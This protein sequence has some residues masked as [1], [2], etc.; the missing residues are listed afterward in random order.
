MYTTLQKKSD[1]M[2]NLKHNKND[3][4]SV[5]S[6]L[7]AWCAEP[8]QPTPSPSVS[9]GT[10]NN[11]LVP[12]TSH[13]ARRLQHVSCKDGIKSVSLS[14]HANISAPKQSNS[15]TKLI[16]INS[17]RSTSLQLLMQKAVLVIWMCVY[18]PTYI[19]IC[20]SMI[21]TLQFTAENT[22]YNR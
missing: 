1:G 18:I 19:N 12:S 22:T 15:M 21:Y 7:C 9:Q 16:T 6:N 20:V 14:G 8:I 13:L 5:D 2:L 11:Q 10:M 4:V 3:F 17:Y